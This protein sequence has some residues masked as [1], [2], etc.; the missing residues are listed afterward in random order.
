MSHHLSIDI[1][2]YSSVDIRAAGMYKYAQSP[3]FEVLLFAYSL[4]GGPV[5]VVDFTA[6]EHIP[7]V[8]MQHLFSPATIKHAWNAAFE[9]YCLSRHFT[10][11][12]VQDIHWLHQWQDTMLHAMYCGYPGSLAAAGKAAGLSEDKKKL[13]TGRALIRTFCIPRTPTSRDKRTRIL[14]N[15]EPDKWR[16]FKEYNAQD[17]VTE[18]EIENRLSAFPVPENLWTEWVLDQIINYRGIQVDLQLVDGALSCNQVVTEQLTADAIDITGMEN[19]NSLQQ[20]KDWFKKETGQDVDSLTKQTVTDML[21]TMPEGP[22]RRMLEIRQELGKTSV[23][24]Y[25][26]LESATGADGRI[27]GTLQFYGANRTGRWAG[28]LVQVQNLPRTY[29]HGTGMSL[30]RQWVREKKPEH[31]KYVLGT[32]PD[33]L[34]QLVRTAF[35]PSPGHVFVDADFSAIEARV[36]AWLA[37]EDWVLDVFRTHGK[38]YEACAAQMFGVPIEKITK[39]NP[40]YDLRQRGK[41]ATLAL[42]Y[43]GGTGS[44]VQMGALRQ[45]IPEEDL[46]DI[47]K[48]WRAANRHI[49]DLWYAVEAAAIA[50]IKTGQ[51][52]F[53]RNVS[54]QMEGNSNRDFMTVTLPSGRKLYY[55]SPVIVPG[56][57]GRDSIQFMGMNQTTKKWERIDTY[58]GKLVEN[59]VQATARDCLSVNIL[60]LEEAGFPI[61][62]HVH[63][64]VVIDCPKE[65]A[66]L[67]RVCRIMSRPI[68]WAPG[69]P[70][71]AEG[72]TGDYYTKE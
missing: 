50:T 45:G 59:I 69:L 60:R 17:V 43:Q 63:D 34:S 52:T 58:G 48:R 54:F 38:I 42:G 61:V 23:K 4:D 11:M 14:P 39:G 10:D 51:P 68:D 20:L 29:I 32:V 70:L 44:L 30:A 67:D 49:V 9:W 40:E 64:E 6:G 18:A 28:R 71:K 36:I 57:F 62:F 41:V 24:K 55:C 25:A 19:P 33:I 7:P 2:T 31:I 66:D 53:V 12:P 47:V 72:W 46:P 15:H 65:Q 22:A 5:E 21:Q 16:L 13:S 1:E 26:A 37:G 56:T 8:I 35:V 3:D 27:R